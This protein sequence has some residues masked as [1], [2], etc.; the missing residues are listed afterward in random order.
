MVVKHQPCMQV[1]IYD[2]LYHSKLVDFDSQLE[3]RYL[4]YALMKILISLKE[5]IRV[6][7]KRP[8]NNY[9]D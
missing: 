8:L 6:E 9:L 1:L 5:K 7:Q 2:L 3:A 4:E